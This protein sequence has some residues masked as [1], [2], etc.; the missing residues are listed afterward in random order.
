MPEAGHNLLRIAQV[1]KSNGTDGELVL[2]FRDIAPEDIDIEE[3]VFIYFDGLPV[4]FFIESFATRGTNKALVHLTDV[5]SIKD[6]EEL[7]GKAIYIKDEEGS[8][9]ESL[10]GLV[11]WTVMDSCHNEIGIISDFYDIPG[12]PCIEVG[13]ISGTVMIP[14][15]EDL[16]ISFDEDNKILEMTVPDGLI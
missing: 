12:N 8:S 1:L 7:S 10:E 5:R 3:P 15:H 16:V 11:G 9:E 14:L 13:T 6:A 4:P 2:G